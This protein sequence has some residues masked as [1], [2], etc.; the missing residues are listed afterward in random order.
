[1]LEAVRVVIGFTKGISL[2]VIVPEEVGPSPRELDNSL[3]L[4]HANNVC[5]AHKPRTDS[6]QN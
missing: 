5:F 2:G 1:M 6:G 3:N 4:G